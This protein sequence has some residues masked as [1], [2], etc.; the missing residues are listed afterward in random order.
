[1]FFEHSLVKE[2][3]VALSTPFMVN[4]FPLQLLPRLMSQGVLFRIMFGAEWTVTSFAWKFRD[5][6]LLS[7]GN[8]LGKLLL[9]FFSGISLITLGD[10]MG[11]FLQPQFF[12]QQSTTI[13]QCSPPYKKG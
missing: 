3:R 2:N 7:F 5:F 13:K 10:L 6:V 4:S 8:L 9:V 1:M 12:L 11:R